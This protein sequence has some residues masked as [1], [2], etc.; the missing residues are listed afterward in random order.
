MKADVGGI[1]PHNGHLAVPPAALDNRLVPSPIP[2][3]MKLDMNHKYSQI[4]QDFMVPGHYGLHV[5]QHVVAASRLDQNNIHA[6]ARIM[7]KN[8][9]VTKI[10]VTTN[11]GVNGV[12]EQI[13]VESNRLELLL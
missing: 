8:E 7:F 10:P 3:Q 6:A 9:P 5:V 2:A 4:T 13:T 11:N 12:I 1:S